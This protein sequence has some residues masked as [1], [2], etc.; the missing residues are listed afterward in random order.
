VYNP[1]FFL[2]FSIWGMGYEFKGIRNLYMNFEGVLL[3]LWIH[4][5]MAQRQGQI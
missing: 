1:L 4:S 2:S 3:I 5:I